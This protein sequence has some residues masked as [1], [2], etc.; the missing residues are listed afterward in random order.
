[1]PFGVSSNEPKK[2]NFV[3][4]RHPALSLSQ[5][6]SVYFDDWEAIFSEALSF[7]QSSTP[8]ALLPLYVSERDYSDFSLWLWTRRL[9]VI[10]DDRCFLI[11][12]FSF[13]AFGSIVVDPCE[14]KVYVKYKFLYETMVNQT[15]KKK[16]NH[17][18]YS[19]FFSMMPLIMI[20]LS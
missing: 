2:G 3:V 19:I 14:P 9:C 12:A 11:V 5:T 15:F 13:P 10:S 1:M 20:Y 8:L 16:I 7:L 4:V 6:L 18:K 17:K